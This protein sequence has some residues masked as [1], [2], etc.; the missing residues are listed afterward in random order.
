MPDPRLGRAFAA[1]LAVLLAAL[2]TA[3][4]RAQD[5][6]DTAF[7]LTRLNPSARSA[8][9]AGATDAV[10]AGRDPAALYS[11]PAR[12]GA[13]A[14]GVL[15]LGYLD[16]LAGV[17]AGFATY[18]RAL[19]RVGR[20]ALGVRYL[21]YGELDGV[22]GSGAETGTFGAGE[23]AVTLSA[24]RDV[25]ERLR[26]GA[27]A[28]ALFASIAEADAQ[29]LAADVGAVY[30]IP[31][32]LLTVSASVRGVGAVVSSLGEADDRL[33]LDVRVGVAKRLR[34]LPLTL[35]VA[36][37]DLQSVGAAEGEAFLDEAV[38]HVGAGGELQLGKA[39]ALR[40]GYEPARREALRSGGRL[41]LAGVTA[42]FGLDT[43]RVALDYAYGAWSDYG[44]LH[45]FG[46]RVGL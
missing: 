29:A 19:P 27:S 36:G 14:E 12:L 34:Y 10:E 28:H 4:P 23:A 30:S 8:A 22:D 21:S 24:S 46:V 40:L 9:L 45:Q 7:D 31:S 17:R 43:R 6:R 16:H 42:G 33:P 35:T 13:D 15:A 38:R 26:V 39:L 2:S 20:V 11:N 18:A 25:S 5:S 44:G 37:F 3:A 32:Q 1:A 41:D